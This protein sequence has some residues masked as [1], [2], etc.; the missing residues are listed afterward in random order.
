MLEGNKVSLSK[1]VDLAGTIGELVR[2][3][4]ISKYRSISKLVNKYHQKCFLILFPQPCQT[5]SYFVLDLIS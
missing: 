4:L 5:G 2:L 3:K 1:T